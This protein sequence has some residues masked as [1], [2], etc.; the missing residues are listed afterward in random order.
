M[1]SEIGICN[2][3]LIKL[4]EKTILS[5]D[6]DKKAARICKSL[7]EPTRDY[8]LRTHPWNFAIKRVELARNA[9]DPVYDYAY[10]Y[11]LPSDCLRVLLPNRETWPYGIEGRNMVSDYPDGLIKYIARITDPNTFDDSFREALAC[12]IAAEGAV[13]LTDNDP[14][15]KA[16][17]QLYGLAIADAKSTNAMEAGPKWIESEEWIESRYQGVAGPTGI[18]R[19]QPK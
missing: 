16:M 2:R 19:R 11:K 6:D 9:T 7:Y 14:R 17:V 3:A 12:K 1:A 13:A 10:S 18:I 4:G 5:L 8:V 15:H